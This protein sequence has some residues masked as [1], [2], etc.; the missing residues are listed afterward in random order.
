MSIESLVFQV[1]YYGLAI[2]ITVGRNT[3]GISNYSMN[4]VFL[5]NPIEQALE[6]VVKNHGSQ[7]V[8]R[9]CQL[10]LS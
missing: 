6:Y 9:S 1:F 5:R 8:T 7:I 3:N 10:F 4:I 2:Q